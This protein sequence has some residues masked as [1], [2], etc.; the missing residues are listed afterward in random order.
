V[1]VA[2]RDVELGVP[3]EEAHRLDADAPADERGAEVV[4]ERVEGPLADASCIDVMWDDITSS[5]R[6]FYCA[7]RAAMTALREH[8]WN[9]A[10]RDQ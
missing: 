8:E 5:E 9:P 1:H 2:L 6:A 3:G 7:T 10:R 4:P